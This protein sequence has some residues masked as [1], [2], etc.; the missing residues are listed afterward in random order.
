[1]IPVSFSSHSRTH[2][3]CS[4]VILC[5]EFHSYPL[6]LL[7]LTKDNKIR[8]LQRVV[9]LSSLGPSHVAGSVAY[10]SS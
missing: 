2:K 5:I 3:A 6:E 8:G 9:L 7:E 10:R 1:L 4:T